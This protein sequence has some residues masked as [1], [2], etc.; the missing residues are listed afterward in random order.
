MENILFV[1]FAIIFTIL[2]LII[3]FIGL[4]EVVIYAHQ[5]LGIPFDQSGNYAVIVLKSSLIG[6]STIAFITIAF[7]LMAIIIQVLLGLLKSRP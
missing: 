2:A 1:L 7:I 4:S 6:M 3:W 5:I